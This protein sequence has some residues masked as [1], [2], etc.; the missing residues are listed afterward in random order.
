MNV[1]HFNVKRLI[2]LCTRT[3]IKISTYVNIRFKA[4]GTLYCCVGLITSPAHP[5]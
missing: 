2:Q 3:F 4:N 1:H 5:V